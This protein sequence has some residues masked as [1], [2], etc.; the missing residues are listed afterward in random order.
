MAASI[1]QVCSW[2]LRQSV[3][4]TP[5]TRSSLLGDLSEFFGSSDFYGGMTFA[6]NTALYRALPDGE[7]DLAAGGDTDLATVV[8]SSQQNT[9]TINV[10][11]PNDEYALLNTFS[12]PSYTFPFPI[13]AGQIYRQLL[14]QWERC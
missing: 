2:L 4:K 6:T 14:E 9:L 11:E 3:L 8:E 10:Y 1:S 7:G 5:E 12:Y 13:L